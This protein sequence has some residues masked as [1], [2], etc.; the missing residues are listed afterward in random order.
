MFYKENYQPRI[1]DYDRNGKLSYEAILQILESAGSHHSDSAG[2]SVI[3]GSQNGIAWILTDWRVEIIYRTDSKEKLYI[4]TWVRGKAPASMVF[5]NFILTDSNGNEVIRAEAKFALLDLSTGRLTRI[6]EALLE[7]YQPENKTVFDTA[8]QRLHAPTEFDDEQIITL[9]RSD[10]DFN[11][12]V[13]NTRY[14][15]FAL[16][17]LPEAFYRNNNVAEIHIVYMK[18][19][20][21]SS[22]VTVKCSNA[23]NKYR[24]CIYSED[25]LC[26]LCEFV[27]EAI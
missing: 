9:R 13:H 21:E 16:E 10:I 3:K 6:S 19:L 18:P 14:M 15:D 7:S 25:V 23:E 26:T 5:R 8:T 27:T 22:A 20:K 24:I 4:T 2:D 1:S 11:G 12:H 17:I